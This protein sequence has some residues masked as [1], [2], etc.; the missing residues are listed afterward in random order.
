MAKDKVINESN[1]NLL[2]TV[3][4]SKQYI[5][6]QEQINCISKILVEQADVPQ[7]LVNWLIDS[8]KENTKLELQS[9]K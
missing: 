7:K 9:K 1:S 5:Q 4:N 6:N 3:Y 2:N 8:V